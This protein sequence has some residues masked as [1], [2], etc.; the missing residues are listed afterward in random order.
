[1]DEFS[2]VFNSLFMSSIMDKDI[3]IRWVWMG[4]VVDRD[5]NGEVYGTDRALASRWG[6]SMPQFADALHVLSG[7]DPDSTSDKDEGRRIRKVSNNRWLVVNHEEYRSSEQYARQKE[8]ARERQQT[9]RDKGRHAPSRSVTLPSVSVSDS[10]GTIRASR[11]NTEESLEEGLKE[12]A[13]KDRFE[14][15]WDL[16]GK[17]VGKSKCSDRFCALSIKAQTAA[18]EAI[19][20]HRKMWAAE[21]RGT[22]YMPNP[23]TW[24][25]QKKWEDEIT[26]EMLEP[27][28]E[29][30][31][32]KRYEGR[33]E[34]DR[35]GDGRKAKLD[36]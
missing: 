5:K 33:N 30:R 18:I 29:T 21:Q 17:K 35:D 8:Q 9:K 2:L 23:Q 20:R 24:I 16:Y 31:P 22:K 10:S 27:H 11:D 14:T 7:P 34:Y 25:N 6:V 3:H 32:A 13:S 15:F 4:F 1:M 19:P 36:F 26:D 28:R 12:W